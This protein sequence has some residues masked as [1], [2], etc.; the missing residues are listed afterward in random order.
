MATTT[1]RLVMEASNNLHDV[2]SRMELDTHADTC[3][4]GSN[5]VVLDLTGKVAKVSPFCEDDSTSTTFDDIP[6]ATVATAYHCP[7]TGKTYI[8]VINESLYFGDKMTHSLL[9]PNQLRAHGVKVDD[10]PRQNDPTSTH[11]VHV[12]DSDLRIPLTLRGVISGFVT[13]PPTATE[14]DDFS[15]HVELI[16]D[17]EWE[18]YAIDFSHRE[19]TQTQ[20]DFPHTLASVINQLNDIM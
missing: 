16:S 3:V 20:D 9:C 12:M 1:R 17:T 15:T 4:A 6:I 13:R 11:S 14:L 7:L 19:A 18:P 8:L 5:C 10:C 2:D